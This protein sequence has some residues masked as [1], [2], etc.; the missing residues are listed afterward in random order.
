MTNAGVALC[1]PKVPEKSE[2]AVG[3]RF[4][5]IEGIALHKYSLRLQDELIRIWIYV[6]KCEGHSNLTE[7]IFGQRSAQLVVHK[8][9]NS[10]RFL[11]ARQLDYLE[12][13]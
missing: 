7:Y 8:N 10:F 11:T 5:V 1:V 9:S 3:W 12:K 6:V 13:T 4:S 2:R